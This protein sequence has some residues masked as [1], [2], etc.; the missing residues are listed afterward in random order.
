[1]RTIHRLLQATLVWLT[2]ATTLAA[3]VPHFDCVCPNGHRKQFCLGMSSSGGGCCCGGSC[4]SSSGP[5]K[6][7][8][9]RDVLPK[10]TD[11]QSSC[12]KSHRPSR[13]NPASTHVEK[14]S[15]CTKTLAPGELLS[16]PEL[17]RLLD[18][19]VMEEFSVPLSMTAS[20]S[21]LAMSSGRPFCW[22]RHVLP[23]PTD[24]VISLQHFLI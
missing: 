10:A 16:A 3:S 19:N 8:S 23:P 5:G 11:E 14:S 12:C 15:C 13:P 1:M 20:V 17:K 24:L 4:C 18:Q 2:A 22:R 6:C 9:A 21:P 7:C